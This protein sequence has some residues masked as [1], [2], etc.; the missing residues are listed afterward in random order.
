MPALAPVDLAAAR[1]ALASV[2]P[3]LTR[4]IRSIADPTRHA[5]GLW[6]AGD[7]AVHLANAW[8]LIPALAAGRVAS[9]LGEL[10]DLGTLTTAAVNAERARDCRLLAGRIEVAAG[11]F[12]KA[13]ASVDDRCAA[14][15]LVRGVEMPIAVFA[16]HLL[17]ESLV[18]GD[19]IARAEGRA[20]P[21]E[22]RHA[23]L[24]VEGFALPVMAALPPSAMVDERRAG[25]LRARY[26]VSLRGGRST[27]VAIDDG[28]LGIE[29]YSSQ[30]VDCHISA[31]ADAMLLV[32]Y[33]RRNLWSAIAR[34]HIAA[35]G[36]RPWLAPLLRTALRNP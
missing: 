28:V 31:D 9:P 11:G 7:V 4:S 12:I 2:V 35:W 18:H 20:W 36:R 26:E 3:R 25:H 27:F 14:P 6:N 13:T 34:G 30:P 33:G 24:A 5:I 21:I 10:S 23:A 16:C 19:D 22:R 15:W 29:P 32:M 8:E 1:V 17:S